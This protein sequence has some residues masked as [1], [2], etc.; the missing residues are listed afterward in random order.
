MAGS[1]V[2]H[3]TYDGSLSAATVVHG[4]GATANVFAST[5]YAFVACDIDNEIIETEYVVACL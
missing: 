2:T 5:V 4:V 3:A 1:K